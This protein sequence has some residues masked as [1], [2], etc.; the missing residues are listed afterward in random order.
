ME[1]KEFFKRLGQH[2]AK[3]AVKRDRCSCEQCCYRTFCYTPPCAMLG[4]MV[5]TVQRLLKEGE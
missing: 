2:C 5:D 1:V 4:N 3:E